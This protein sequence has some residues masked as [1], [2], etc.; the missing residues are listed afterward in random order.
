MIVVEKMKLVSLGG[1]GEK[2]QF[3][4]SSAKN[5]FSHKRFDRL[6]SNKK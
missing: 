4:S 1:D 2:M 3:S 6:N 5:D